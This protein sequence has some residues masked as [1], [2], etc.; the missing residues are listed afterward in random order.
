MVAI[1]GT[2]FSN[3]QDFDAAQWGASLHLPETVTK[4]LMQAWAFC[5]NH[6]DKTS[7]ASYYRFAG[8]EMVD[9]LHGLNMDAESLLTAMLYPT[10]ASG[11]VSVDDITAAFG[12]TILKLLQEVAEM[13]NIRQLNITSGTASSTQV[14]NVRRMLLA[15]VDDFR[16]VIIK[17]AERII[18][19]RDDQ[20]SEENRVL[21]AKECSKIYAPLAN[22]LGIGQLKWEL[23]DY[24]FRTLHPET[25]R[26]IA[27]LLKERRVDRENYIADFV[28]TLRHA[29]KDHL[30]EVDVYG[31][32]KHIYSIW[33]K[34]QKKHIEF[35]EL[36]DVRAVRVIVQKL[37]DCYA[38]LGV[39]HTH[40]NHLPK[41][42][43]DYVANPKP[44]G[45]QSI[46]TVVLGKGGKP[47]EVQIRTQQMHDDAELGV[48]AHWKY[49]EGITG[50]ER[51]YEE[52]I[53]WL[54]KLL[55]WQD[56][57]VDSGDI[58][59]EVRSQV[60]DDRVYVFTPKGEVVDLPTGATPLDFAYAIHSEIGHRCIGA[61][62]GGRI[63]PFTYPLQMGDQVEIL[64]QKTPNPSRD[65]TN[66]ALG[67]TKTAKARARINA[68]FKK[69]DRE[70]NTPLGK[71]LLEVGLNASHFDL[72]HVEKLV[73][74]RYNLHHLDDLYAAIGCGDIR[75]AAVVSFL[76]NRQPQNSAQKSDAEI[77][78]QVNQRALHQPAQ[79]P[80][81]KKDDG[82]A[83]IVDGVGN[84]LHYMA[85]C[86]QPIL[87]DPIT[88]YITMG[89][90]ISI[91]RTDCEQF[92]EMQHQHPERVVEAHWGSIPPSKF[93]VTLLI[94]TGDRHGL[95]RDITT[96]LANDKIN[97][98][99]VR[100]QNDNKL[101][102]VRIQLDVEL[103]NLAALNK[104][105]ARLH[106]INDVIDVKRI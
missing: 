61:K 35:S 22:R 51:G 54:R 101:Q 39:V 66:P 94:I 47:V 46:H 67:F 7:K 50:G 12:K 15:M 9:I 93:A 21:A 58:M 70:K 43:D 19:L 91:H 97:V 76:Q 89:R 65:W 3:P 48:A 20:Q 37:Q 73:L 79:K 45:Y 90:G 78:R 18:F 32:P 85:G 17:L 28:Q 103:P 16:C 55:A 88:G 60:F 83:V 8:V 71:E 81:R 64:T 53:A 10:F 38:A 98:N 99:S 1:R 4:Q 2:H 31:R 105:L 77:L 42:F 80:Q 106:K 5:E 30:Q 40:F 59:A 26:Q 52:K 24:C 92:L 41:E 56:D 33:K 14:D 102:H 29:L 68:F 75:V 74:P 95:L 36:Y 100:L 49:K 72:K 104:V 63:V 96:V 84:L 34:M 11:K 27:K 6:S 25:Y 13:D 62:V 86:C 69:Q 82:D 23:E 57:I 87:G 44:N